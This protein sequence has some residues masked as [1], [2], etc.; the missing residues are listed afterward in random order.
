MQ[1]ITEYRNKPR[2][3]RET[4]D[5]LASRAQYLIMKSQMAGNMMFDGHTPTAEEKQNAEESV[6]LCDKIERQLQYC[7]ANEI[8]VLISCYNILFMVGNR[9]MPDRAILD[10]HKRRV[11]DAWKRGDRTIEESDVFGLIAPDAAYHPETANA[12]Y[13]RIYLTMKDR[14]LD[15]LSKFNRFPDVTTAENYERLALVMRE[16]LDNRFGADSAKM[17]RKWYTAN[18]IDDLTPLTT[19]ILRAYRQFVTALFPAVLTYDRM[20]RLDRAVLRALTSRPDLDPFDRQAYQLA[21][22][23]PIPQS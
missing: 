3:P 1:T 16:S 8:P 23:L 18:R 10:R 2:V 12:E 15:T 11:V 20:T 22:T 13:V 17:K 5:M 7:K 6:R 9:R 19:T 14:W 4:P 21:L